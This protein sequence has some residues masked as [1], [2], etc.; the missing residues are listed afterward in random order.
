MMKLI[1]RKKILKLKKI[2]KVITFVM[3][4]IAIS[5]L[6]TRFEELQSFKGIFRFLMDSITLKSLDT[7]ELRECRAK[8]ANTFSFMVH[9]ML[10]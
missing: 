3:V 10:I 1:A 2:L 5:S 4:D 6:K 8:F 7:I 9:H